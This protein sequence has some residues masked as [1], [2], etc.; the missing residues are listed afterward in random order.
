MSEYEI[1][2]KEKRTYLERLI[3]EVIS[4]LRNAIELRVIDDKI[5]L[6]E[7]LYRLT[8]RNKVYSFFDDLKNLVTNHN[9]LSDIQLKFIKGNFSDIEKQFFFGAIEEFITSNPDVPKPLG[10]GKKYVI[11][12]EMVE[13]ETS[14]EL[15][16]LR[17]KI[18][19]EWYVEDFVNL[20]KS[21]D[22][23]YKVIHRINFIRGNGVDY[24]EVTTDDATDEKNLKQT[25][26]S[27][28]NLR[29]RHLSY[30]SPGF[31]DFL[32]LGKICSELNELIHKVLMWRANYKTAKL[33]EL[34]KQ[35]D[36]LAKL[37]EKADN[38][39]LSVRTKT[40]IKEEI[41]E[42]ILGVLKAS[43]KGKITGTLLI[44]DLSDHRN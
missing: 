38:L 26:K 13:S 21:I 14:T 7:D 2:I 6:S 8:G 19:G 12:R 28:L 22:Q 42:S 17:I 16:A 1:P 11:T 27:L 24:E 32:G 10:R 18:N 30:S 39:D 34:D 9:S 23:L 20:F 37:M 31:T 41:N 40:A 43:G 44:T 5:S 25:V 36:L 4:H 33:T 3:N 35:V 29:V 15:A